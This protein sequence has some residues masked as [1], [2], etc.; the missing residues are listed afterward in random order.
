MSN[1][2][3][4]RLARLAQHPTDELIENVDQL[5]QVVFDLEATLKT[6]TS[7]AHELPIELSQ[8][9]D[10]RELIDKARMVVMEL[11]RVLGRSRVVAELRRHREEG[12]DD[13]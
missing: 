12:H 1:Q 11:R 10:L 2:I 7:R 8:R 3:A 5:G 6:A 13:G 4:E 9:E